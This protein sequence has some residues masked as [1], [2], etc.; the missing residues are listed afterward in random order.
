MSYYEIMESFHRRVA[1]IYKVAA[2]KH[3]EKPYV[4]AAIDRVIVDVMAELTTLRG[5]ETKQRIVKALIA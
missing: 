5:Y 4:D 3:L 1:G 2:E